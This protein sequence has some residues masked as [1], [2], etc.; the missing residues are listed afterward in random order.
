MRKNIEAVE[1][2]GAN[3]D[4]LAETT[5]NLGRGA[6]EFNRGASRARR[7]ECWRNQKMTIWIII[8]IIV[9]LLIIIIPSGESQCCSRWMVAR[10]T[11]CV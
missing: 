7:R 2:R 4:D 8:G 10:L 1:K 9:V 5:S 6:R 3:I 11:Y